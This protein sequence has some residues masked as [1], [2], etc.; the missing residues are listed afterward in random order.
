MKRTLLFAISFIFSFNSYLNAQTSHFVDV[1]GALDIFNPNSLTINI[2]DT[3]IW[4]NIG[5]F[6]NVNATLTAYPNN[7]EGFG[8]AVSS[9]A[10]TFQHVFTIP[11]TYD[12]KCD[13]HVN[14]GMTG[15]IIVN[16]NPTP[17]TDLFISEYAE[18]SGTNKYIEIFNGTGQDVD[19]SNYQLWKVTNGGTW[20]EYTFN[21]SGILTHN[22]VYIVYSSS[23]SV[24]P[25]I[26]AAGDITW[27]QVTWT[28]DDA[29][30]LAKQVGSIGGATFTLIDAIGEDG[31]DPGTGWNVAGVTN[32]TKD[33]TLVRKCSVNQGNINWSLSA[34]TDALNSEWVVLPQNDWSDIDQHTSPCQS[35]A[36][37][38][39]TDSTALNFDP[40]ATVDDG[41][42][43][44]TIYGCMDSTAFNYSATANTDDGSCCFQAGCTDPSAY[45]YDPAACYNDGSCMTPVFGC[46]NVTAMNFDST[47]TI[48]DGSCVYL[49]DKID[50]F[51]SEYGEGTSNNKYIEIYNTTNNSV[52]LSSYALT[53]V[54]NAPTNV[55][56]Y[57]YWVDF[58]S[59]SV[60][61]ANDVYIIAH[62][63]ADSIIL[64]QSDMTYSV[65]SN[66]D[67][68][69][70]LVYGVEPSSPVLAGNQYVI[71]DYLGDFNGD[72]GSGWSVAGVNE[73]TKDHV[74]IRKCDINTGNTDWISSAGTD[75][76]NSEW[77]VLSNEDWSSI[78]QHSICSPQKTYVPDNNFEQR[79]IQL[80]YDNILDDSVLTSNINTIIS[81][82]VSFQNISSLIGI[83]DFSSLRNLYCN[84]N[85]IINIDVSDLSNLRRFDC[86]WN[87]ITSIDVTQNLDLE[88]FDCGANYITVLDVSN[89]LALTD[90]ACYGNSLTTLDVSNNL[91]LTGLWCPFNSITSLDLSD[92]VSLTNLWCFSNNL[93]MLNVRNGNNINLMQFNA[94]DN[95][96]L[97][98]T[99]VDDPTWMY[100]Y[101]SNFINYSN[102]FSGSCSGLGCT[103][104]LACNYN[105][106][107]SI[108]DGSCQLPDGCTDPLACNYDFDAVCDD[109]SCGYVIGCTDP[110][111]CNYDVL[112]TCDD[113]SCFGISGCMDP[114][115]C[116]YDIS[117][118]CD[119]G[120]CGY[121][122]GCTDPLAC[123][124]DSLAICD[125]G[126]CILPDGCTDPTATNYDPLATCDDG[127]CYQCDLSFS[128][129]SSDPSTPSSC[130]GWASVSMVQTSYL[131]VTYLWNTGSTQSYILNL[132]TAAYT[133]T[134]TDAVGCISDTTF[135]LGNIVP[136]CTDPLACNYDPSA[137][138]D[139]G[140]C[141][142]SCYGCTGPTYCNY[143]PNATIDDGSCSGMS[144]CTDSLAC[145]YDSMA[146]C[147]DG[148][149]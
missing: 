130:D 80:G 132:C 8:N 143:D 71:L 34:G 15:V 78:G 86:Q 104:P 118:T 70:A 44:L 67:D 113:G 106:Y 73:A 124:Y 27:S 74:L 33:H 49:T 93:S 9:S 62:P 85:Y 94:N 25:I 134:V 98:C 5:G 11:G 4:N 16:T 14:M 83:E 117:A 42:C 48:D 65:L 91:S 140:S 126:L 149:C 22:H 128:I 121:V 84:D 46:M 123:N 147:D 6:H 144:G 101:W 100:T 58:D 105:S 29:I 108:D 68:G 76:L 110:L 145:N 97:Y 57:E 43:I 102:T 56:V 32:A 120:S 51:F 95:P 45:N 61:L 96:N 28:G 1:G 127:S 87:S 135:N 81:L 36:V 26:S 112:A 82:D 2:G 111:A 59:G 92:H 37:Y 39:C 66:G 21:L 99:D 12:Y 148:S 129:I 41:S 30:G 55:G 115:A 20:P 24:D 90:L 3:V 141:D 122:I 103:D 50:L 40:L 38:G 114:I 63:S 10:W 125:D 107:A 138:F 13:P 77:I 142:Y 133:V 139:D 72:P 18:G 119:D 7:P 60:I 88:N 54:S 47:A 35:T 136:G 19:L 89:N 31:P 137:T 116:N 52:D 79:L 23:S 109:G 146:N 53:R 131:P 64:A 69:F 75:S 17:P